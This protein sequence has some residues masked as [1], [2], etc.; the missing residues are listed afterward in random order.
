MCLIIMKDSISG[1]KLFTQLKVKHAYIDNSNIFEILLDGMKM[2]ERYKNV[3]GTTKQIYVL[4]CIRKFV[5]E[6]TNDK[7]RET[8]MFIVDYVLPHIVDV[9][10]AI[11]N[12]EI[13]IKELKR[14]FCKCF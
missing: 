9:V 2:I 3:D 10:I 5:Q 13:D 4:E 11:A 6:M 7:E 1:D 12:K 8:L 14:K